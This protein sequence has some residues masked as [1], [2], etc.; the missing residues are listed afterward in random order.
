MRAFWSALL[1]LCL[2]PAAGAMERST[3]LL[4]K[5]FSLQP[6][7]RR[8]AEL[9][10]ASC[11]SCHGERG[12]GRADS[13]MPSLAGQRE[14]YL[15]RQLADFAELNREVKEMHRLEAI[16]GVAPEQQWRDLAAFLA[17]QPLHPST[18]VGDGKSLDIGAGIYRDACAQCHGTRGE[19]DDAILAPALAGQHYSYLLLQIRGMASGHRFSNIEFDLALMLSSFSA[20]DMAAVADYVSRLSHPMRAR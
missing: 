17:A 19:G 12:W 6:D 20:A 1:T 11:A 15:L 7:A 13:A 3:E 18:Q 10:A 2:V 16:I 9:Y 8:G 5:A 4:A 14:P